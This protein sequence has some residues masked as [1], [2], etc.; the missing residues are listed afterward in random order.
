MDSPLSVAEGLREIAFQCRQRARWFGSGVE[1]ETLMAQA[2]EF[3]AE[4]LEIH[5]AEN[6]SK[7]ANCFR[8]TAA[9]D[10]AAR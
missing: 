10:D 7:A 4:A 8:V 3:E 6:C 2:H 1:Y 9:N 5:A